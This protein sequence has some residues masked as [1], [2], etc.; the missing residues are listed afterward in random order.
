MAGP[1][2]WSSEASEP[3][4]AAPASPARRRAAADAGARDRRPSGR[5]PTTAGG[6]SRQRG[7]GGE[8]VEGRQA[9]RELLLAGRRRVREV[10]VVGRRGRAP[11]RT[12][13]RHRRAGR[14]PPGAGA[15][16][17]PGTKL[18]AAGPHRGAPG[19]RRPGPTPLPEADLDDLA[20]TPLGRRRPAVP[21]RRRRRHRPRQPRR[22]AALGRVRRRHRRRAAPPPGRPRHARRSPRRPP[23][24]SST[25]RWPL[26]GGLPAALERLKAA[27]LWVVGL[28]AGGDTPLA[29]LAL[30]RRAGRPRARRR[31]RRP[32]PPRP[33][34]VRRRGGDPAPRPCSS[35]LNVAAAAAIATY[36]IA[37]RRG[38]NRRRFATESRSA[39]SVVRENFRRDR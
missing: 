12:A 37:R 10:L 15:A 2:P 5:R 9:V 25:C 22:P 39:E 35:S 4:A 32:V 21:R 33:P 11:R 17:R 23:A 36:E 1:S 38:V 34:A 13:R 26:V 31:G 20:A 16:G 7:L 24:P 8:Q 18:D 27:G 19:R 6:A 3:A 30:R 14:R 29:E 28:D